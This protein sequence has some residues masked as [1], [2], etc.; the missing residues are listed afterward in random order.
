MLKAS[1]YHKP[2][3]VVLYIV[4]HHVAVDGVSWNI[5]LMDLQRLLKQW[6]KGEVFSLIHN[7]SSY[8]SW[9]LS[10]RTIKK[11]VSDTNSLIPTEKCIFE[12][13]V[14]DELITKRVFN[15]VVFP[16]HAKPIELLLTAFCMTVRSLGDRINEDIQIEYE[17]HGRSLEEAFS[18]EI[19][20]V[21]WFTQICRLTSSIEFADSNSNLRTYFRKIKALYEAS[22]QFGDFTG[23]W[24]PTAARLN[25]LGDIRTDY[26]DFHLIPLYSFERVSCLMEVDALLIEDSLHITL[27]LPERLSGQLHFTLHQLCE[28]LEKIVDYYTNN[29]ESLLSI[30][31]FKEVNLSDSEFESLFI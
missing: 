23:G 8:Q 27:R 11:I 20:T 5:L 14:L 18:N 6:N 21:G 16:N 3:E 1:L 7:G 2:Q 15:D 26:N 25:F 31:D 12:T 13:K 22:E 30:D 29:G 28:N 4:I 19:Q 9:A 10:Q 17:R 24:N